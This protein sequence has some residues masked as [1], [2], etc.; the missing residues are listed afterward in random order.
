MPSALENLILNK[1]LNRTCWS[2]TTV[3]GYA[4]INKQRCK[5]RN[6]PRSIDL[7]LSE[8]NWIICQKVEWNYLLCWTLWDANIRHPPFC[9][10]PF[11]GK[12]MFWKKIEIHFFDFV[13]GRST[14]IW[15]FRKMRLKVFVDVTMFNKL[16]GCEIF[17]A[18]N[19]TVCE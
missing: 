14:N 1:Y 13:I 19:A 11:R 7:N 15:F 3:R 16:I 17:F 9:A 4:F 6:W 2:T 5:K 18:V 8:S 10:L 12:W